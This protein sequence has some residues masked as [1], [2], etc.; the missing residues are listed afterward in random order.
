MLDH[1]AVIS[2]DMDADVEFYLQLGFTV[3]TR[4]E[5]WAMLRDARGAGLALLSPAGNH[6]PHF[7][8]RA[9]S[10]RFIEQIGERY[11][12]PALEHRDGS[13]SVYIKDPSDNW[14]EMIFYPEDEEVGY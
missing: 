4:Y 3:E 14:L 2:R 12:R 1:S 11:S 13:I 8:L 7:A 5:D 9:P 10:R 6:P